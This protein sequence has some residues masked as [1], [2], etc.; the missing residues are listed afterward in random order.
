MGLSSIDTILARSV[1]TPT[2]ELRCLK[3]STS[4]APNL[5]FDIFANN[6]IHI[7]VSKTIL[8]CFKCLEKCNCTP[9]YHKKNKNK[10]QNKLLMSCFTAQ[11]TP[12]GLTCTCNYGEMKAPGWW[13]TPPM[14]KSDAILRLWIIMDW[15][16]KV[17]REFFPSQGG[18]YILDRDSPW[19]VDRGGVSPYSGRIPLLASCRAIDCGSHW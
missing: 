12:W 9:I 10:K 6:L 16:W 5:H 3:Y 13:E 2:P 1:L 15:V 7:E 8:R 11:A 14:L 19:Q 4:A 18:I 17:S